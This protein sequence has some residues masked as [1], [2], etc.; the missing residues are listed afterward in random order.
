MKQKAAINPSANWQERSIATDFEGNIVAKIAQEWALITAG[1]SEDYNTMTASWALMGYLW[2]K[3]VAVCFVRPQRHTR[4]YADKSDF[5]T[6]T[7]FDKSDKTRVHKVCGNQSGRDIDKAE[8]A[9]IT[10]I[11]FGGGIIGFEE[12][13]ET[14]VCKK[15]YFDDF[16]PKHFLDGAIGELYEGDY[17]RFYIG[18]IVKYYKNSSK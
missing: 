10:P 4:T 11:T 9:K 15:I 16:D 18:E 8:L 13:K 3:E 1:T 7:Y 17:H 14:I 2:Q 6:I 5:F 12:A